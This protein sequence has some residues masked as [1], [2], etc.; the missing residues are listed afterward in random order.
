M[1]PPAAKTSS[2]SPERAYKTPADSKKAIEYFLRY[3]KEK[4]DELEVTWLLKIAGMTLGRCPAEVP[5]KFLISPSLFES[6]EDVGRFVDVAFESGLNSFSTAGG[7]IAEDLENNGLLDVVTS[8]FDSCG[9]MHYFHNEGDGT[10]TDREKGRNGVLTANL[11]GNKFRA[12]QLGD[13]VKTV[14]EHPGS[15]AVR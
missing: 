7:V 9:P 5:E 1:R 11:E 4:P 15:G 3:L 10:F 12:D 8:A 6:K 14:L 2:P 13:L